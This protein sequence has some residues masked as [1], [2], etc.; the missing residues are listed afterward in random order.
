MQAGV[1]SS[2]PI[3]NKN[4]FILTNNSLVHKLEQGSN[5]CLY[6][7]TNGNRIPYCRIMLNV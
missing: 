6:L 4:Q 3:V 1:L 2:L 7:E 5:L